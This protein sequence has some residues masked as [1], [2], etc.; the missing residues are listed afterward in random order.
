[1]AQLRTW[2]SMFTFHHSDDK[3]SVSFGML[4]F[5]PERKINLMSTNIVSRT[6]PLVGVVWA[7]VL[8]STTK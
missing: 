2:D 4:D 6:S 1:M 8:P 3:Y 5:L 7:Q